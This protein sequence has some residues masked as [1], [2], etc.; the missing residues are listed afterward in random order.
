MLR[1][2]PRRFALA[3]VLGALVLSS[4]VVAA[5]GNGRVVCGAN[6]CRIVV[7]TPA[8]PGGGTTTPVSDPPSNSGGS[9]SG[10]TSGPAGGGGG[11]SAANASDMTEHVTWEVTDPVT[12]QV[13]QCEAGYLNGQLVYSGASGPGSACDSP[14]GLSGPTGPTA[15]VITITPAQLAQ[16][17]VAQLQL[18]TPQI[19]TAPPSKEDVIGLV[20]VPVW[21]WTDPAQWRPI[22]A[23]AAVPG[24]SVTAV[25]EIGSITWD[26][27]DGTDVVC[28]G[29]GTPYERSYGDQESPDCGHVY[30]RTSGGLPDDSYTITATATYDITWSGAT[31]GSTTRE[32][33][34]STTLP[35]GEAQVIITG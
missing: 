23:T 27:G 13:T 11:G 17:A 14:P 19:G 2:W 24:L 5:Q 26:M 7:E 35:I 29:P 20:G 1:P 12:G 21:L 16:M 25:A 22:S 10:G 30:T 9:G 3:G 8:Q 34:A 6:G 33:S 32:R 31:S 28:T 15:P 18:P 4:V